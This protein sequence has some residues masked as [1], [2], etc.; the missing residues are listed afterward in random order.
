MEGVEQID[1]KYL[2]FLND[3]AS[4]Q[5]ISYFNLRLASGES[6]TF[7]ILNGISK[8]TMTGS[9][10]GFSIQTFID[11]GWGLAVGK[12]FSKK[13][14]TN[15]FLQ[16]AKLGKFSSKYTPVWNQFLVRTGGT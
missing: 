10:Q 12:E 11:G 7:S 2:E 16:S 5:G 8:M 13:E 9:N 14:L 6:S 3:L 1:R 15:V 4:D